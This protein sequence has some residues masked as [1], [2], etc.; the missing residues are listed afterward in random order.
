MSTPV[1]PLASIAVSL[2]RF[3]SVYR[4]SEADALFEKL[5]EELDSFTDMWNQIDQ[6]CMDAGIYCVEKVDDKHSSYLTLPDRV[7]KLS[8]IAA[9]AIE[10]EKRWNERLDEANK[11]LRAITEDRDLWRCEH[12]QD[13]PNAERVSELELELAKAKDHPPCS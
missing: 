5:E 1:R 12:N 7:K 9:Q 11:Q 2:P 8:D 10:R 6:V 3:E 13:C 4:Q